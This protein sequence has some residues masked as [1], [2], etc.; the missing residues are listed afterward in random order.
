MGR[1]VT[2][3]TQLLLLAAVVV[4]VTNGCWFDGQ[5]KHDF[6]VVPV[7]SDDGWEIGTPESVGLSPEAL[8]GIHRVLLEEE[9]FPGSLGMLVIKDE[10][11]V[12]ETYLRTPLDR[13]RY[14]HIQSVTKSVTALAF[15]IARDDGLFPSLDTTIADLFPEKMAGLDARKPAITLRHLFTMSSGLDF[16]NADFSVE[17]WVDKPADPLR[18]ILDKPLYAAPGTVFRYRDVDPQVVG[19]AIQR[20]LGI[21]ERDFVV[22]RLFAPLGIRDY[23]WESG[24]D[25][26]S[27]AAHGLHLRP[28]DLAKIGQFVLDGGIWKGTRIVSQA[29]VDQMTSAQTTSSTPGPDGTFFRYG[30]YWWVVPNGVSAWGHGGQFVLLQ[31]AQ[32]LVIV[33]IALPD[34]A[35]LDGSH[36]RDFVRLVA[37]LMA[38][39]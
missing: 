21:S 2:R 36:L 29:W 5:L 4:L 32:R 20:R 23:S 14:H 7:P 30:Y 37:P 12:W 10:K 8:R 34:T 17:M 35:D 33:H 39:G 1:A 31:P 6:G 15:G 38:G 28:R 26:V 16:D 9:R 11:L 13:D 25:G 22:Q 3:V 19:Y 24:S 18:Y 27:L